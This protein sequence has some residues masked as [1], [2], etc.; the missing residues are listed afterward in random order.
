M[1][2]DPP[3][4]PALVFSRCP[5]DAHESKHAY[6]ASNPEG[7]DAAYRRTSSIAIAAAYRRAAPHYVLRC[8][9]QRLLDVATLLA[10]ADEVIE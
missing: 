5:R 9:Q 8:R 3:L 1:L 6:L 10:R 4:G 2:G 7:G